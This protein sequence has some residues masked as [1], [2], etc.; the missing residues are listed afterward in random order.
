[1]IFEKLQEFRNTVYA[2]L[3]RAKDA[4]FELMDA[5]LTS[6][7]ASSFVRLSLSPV[8]RRQWSSVYAAVQE[9]RPSR[10]KLMKQYV[11]QIPPGEQPLLAGDHTAWSRP[12][13][14]T[15]QDRTFEHDPMRGN[16]PVSVGQGYST[17][18]WIPEASGSWALPLRHDRITS[19]ETPLSK[20]AFQLNQVTQQMTVRPLAVFDREYG[21]GS[22]VNQTRAIPADLL[23]CLSSHRCVW[24]APPPYQG[25]G[26][27]RK[28]GDKFKLNDP[29]RWPVPTECLEVD[30][31]K[32]GLVKLTRW[33]RL[34]F[35]NA[36]CREMEVIRVEVLQPVGRKRHFKPLGLAWLG[37][38]MPP[39]AQ[40]W[41]QYLR[42][43]AV[44]HWYRF[45][46]Q[47]LHW[48]LPQLTNVKATER[49]SDLMAIM[50]WQLWLARDAIQDHPL[51]WQAPQ[52]KLCPGRVAQ[53][54]AVI[55]AAIGTPA[56]PPKLRGNSPGWEPGRPRPPKPRY[57]TVKKRA[58][59]QKKSAKTTKPAQPNVA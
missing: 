38:V 56:K 55:L 1:M 3:G 53:G 27:P 49:W 23:L 22:F 29:N 42:R 26:A 11:A 37:K 10:T 47:R 50:T 39:L 13:A 21:N 9:S 58:A 12:D 52:D 8:F 15:L 40:L 19:F 43:F 20:A 25:R 36:A 54:F 18:A 57:P 45:A 4:A 44:D 51:P 24:G 16:P 6:S 46:K 32:I 34:H 7:S 17:L 14:V 2:S 35:Q 28:H 5:V 48:T 59:T 30:D 31:P 33:S 41:L